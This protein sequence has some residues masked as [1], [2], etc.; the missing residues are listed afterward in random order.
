[1]NILQFNLMDTLS[2][3]FKFSEQL[4]PYCLES[5]SLHRRFYKGIDNKG[6]HKYTST[7]CQYTTKRILG[8]ITGNTWDPI[9]MNDFDYCR[10]EE[11]FKCED[12]NFLLFQFSYPGAGHVLGYIKLQGEYYKIE[13]S[14]NEFSQ[15]FTKTDPAQIR[16]YIY[17]IVNDKNMYNIEIGS[18]AVPDNDVIEHNFTILR[19]TPISDTNF[20]THKILLEN[21]NYNYYET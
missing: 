19:N 5:I 14:L 2:L 1:M 9:N 8:L 11:F 20:D 17:T 7:L 16:E 18:C 10:L 12:N 4:I 3:L 13:S 6:I 21:T 15:Q